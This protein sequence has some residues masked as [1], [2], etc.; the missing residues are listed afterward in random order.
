M[1]IEKITLG[2]L[3]KSEL[4]KTRAIPDGEGGHILA[5]EGVAPRLFHFD[6][7]EKRYSA[8]FLVSDSSEKVEFICAGKTGDWMRHATQEFLLERQLQEESGLGTDRAATSCSTEIFKLATAADYNLV[9]SP[10]GMMDLVKRDEAYALTLTNDVWT[11]EQGATP[12][13]TEK[14]W[15]C[16]RIETQG[17]DEIGHI[18]LWEPL[19]LETALATNEQ[20]AGLQVVRPEEVELSFETLEDML[21]ELPMQA[22]PVSTAPEAAISSLADEAGIVDFLG[23]DFVFDDDDWGLEEVETMGDDAP[24]LEEEIDND[25]ESLPQAELQSSFGF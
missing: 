21:A 9:A 16:S 19:P 14:A 13:A 5:E 1:D 10:A 25:V 6:L 23:E 22:A 11:G 2:A 8:V 3:T 24:L 4:G 18:Q 17:R 7:D 20:L 15:L 12:S